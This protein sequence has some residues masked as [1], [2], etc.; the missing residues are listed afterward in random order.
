MYF[1]LQVLAQPKIQKTKHVF[2]CYE[3]IILSM[4]SDYLYTITD[5][6]LKTKL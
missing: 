2:K 4:R 6:S 3:Q 5:L 1:Y